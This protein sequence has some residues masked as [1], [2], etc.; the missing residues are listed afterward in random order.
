MSRFLGRELDPRTMMY[1]FRD[2]SGVPLPFEARVE[3]ERLA[4]QQRVEYGSF[5]AVSA[6]I[7]KWKSRVESLTAPPRL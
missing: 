5:W 7:Q 6:L 1:R 4:E 3:I 2:G